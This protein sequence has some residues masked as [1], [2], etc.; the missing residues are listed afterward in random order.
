[1]KKILLP[2]ATALA[3]LGA[4]NASATSNNTPFNVKVDLTSSCSVVGAITDVQ[5]TYTS[6]QAGPAASTG[7]N[8]SVKC[9]SGLGYSFAFNPNGNGTMPTVGLTY[10]LTAPASGTGNGAN[11]ALQITGS[12]AGGQGGTCSTAGG[13]CSDTDATKQLTITF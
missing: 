10:T 2:L 9:T 11:Q 5:F 4:A 12:M 8:F 3:V 6:F 1:M 7:G 13:L